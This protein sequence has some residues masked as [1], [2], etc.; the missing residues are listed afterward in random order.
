MTTVLIV[1]CILACVAVVVGIVGHLGT[2]IAADRGWRARI[3]RYHL[4]RRRRSRRITAS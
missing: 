2:A 1:I 3:H 4:A